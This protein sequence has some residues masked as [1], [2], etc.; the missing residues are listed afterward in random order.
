MA[1]P[2]LLHI[3]GVCPDPTTVFEELKEY[4]WRQEKIAMYGKTFDEPRKVMWFAPKGHTY[5]YA[6]KKNEPL[7]MTQL[8]IDLGESAAAVI[9][10]EIGRKVE[11]NSV[12][13]NLY[14]NGDNYIGWHADDEPGLASDVIASIS[15]GATRDFK[16]RRNSDKKVWTYPLAHGDLAVMYDDCQEKYKHSLPKRKKVTEPR[17][18]LTY[19]LYE[20]K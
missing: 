13:C 17:I 20:S 2:P 1:N 8:L 18:N 14:Q 3:P 12:F 4:P 6:G 10:D 5:V 9:E 16:V 19:R 11:F 7:Q 15:L